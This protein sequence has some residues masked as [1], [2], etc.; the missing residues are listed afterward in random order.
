[1][2]DA[3]KKAKGRQ[4]FFEHWPVAQIARAIGTPEGTVQKWAYGQKNTKPENTWLYQRKA[5]EKELC[6]AVVED[7]K[8]HLQRL[9]RISVPMITDAVMARAKLASEG[10]MDPRTKQYVKEPVTLQEAK[11]ITEIITS[12]DKLFRLPAEGELPKGDQDALAYVPVTME[13]LK[14]AVMKDV[15]AD[16][17]DITPVPPK[18]ITSGVSATRT[19]KEPPI[20][21]RRH[22]ED[23]FAE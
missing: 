20:H 8:F 21:M 9:Y 4:M 19:E 3:E 22:P 15:F 12:M 13:D 16:V 5:R 6:D 11:C 2:S 10:R 1:M 17:R 18:E 23:D 14:R 7:N